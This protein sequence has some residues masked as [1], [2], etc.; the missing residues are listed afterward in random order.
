[1]GSLRVGGHLTTDANGAPKV[2]LKLVPRILVTG[3]LDDAAQT[4]PGV[5]DNDINAAKVPVDILEERISAVGRVSDIIFDDE[6]FVRGVSCSEPREAM[7]LARDSG[8]TFASRNH[9]LDCRLADTGRST[10]D[11]L[12]H[13]VR[14]HESSEQRPTH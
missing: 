10:S 13:G 12:A 5:V 3:G 4:K 9:L 2:D 11:Y 7:C 6:E 14:D 8:N 1:M